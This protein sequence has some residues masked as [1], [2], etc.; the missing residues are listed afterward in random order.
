[1]DL[2]VCTGLNW[3][4]NVFHTDRVC[5]VYIVG[6]SMVRGLGSYTYLDIF[7]KDRVT[8]VHDRMYSVA[9]YTITACF[10]GFTVERVFKELPSAL[11][12]EQTPIFVLFLGTN[13]CRNFINLNES[14][15][16]YRKVVLRV[17]SYHR[18][19][20][21]LCVSL[22]RAYE[23]HRRDVF[24]LGYL[25]SRIKKFNCFVNNLAEEFVGSVFYI[26]LYADFDILSEKRR[27]DLMLHDKLHLSVEGY[28]WANEKLADVISSLRRNFY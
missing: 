12:L 23:Q 2:G 6:D 1:M 8:G 5:S 17:L 26:N 3:Q 11:S 9:P 28:H 27:G 19:S 20:K 24:D 14:F 18:N 7:K 15:D 10:P 25:N 4:R 16:V 22:F 13:D 21:I